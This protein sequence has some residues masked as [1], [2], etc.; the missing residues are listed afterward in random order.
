MFPDVL[1]CRAEKTGE[2]LMTRKYILHAIEQ[3]SE[4][5]SPRPASDELERVAR[6]ERPVTETTLAA[7]NTTSKHRLWQTSRHDQKGVTNTFREATRSQSVEACEKSKENV[8]QM[9]LRTHKARPEE[10]HQPRQVEV[11]TGSSGTDVDKVGAKRER[12]TKHMKS[13]KDN[14]TEDDKAK[15]QQEGDTK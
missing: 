10:V 7:K 13:M 15:M 11:S 12:A 9:V 1:R 6:K 4:V 2:V 3:L 8:L 14:L 5:L